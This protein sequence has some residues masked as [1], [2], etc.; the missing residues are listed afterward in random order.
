MKP[1]HGQDFLKAWE[2]WAK[3]VYD[4][5]LADGTIVSYSLNTEYYHTEAPGLLTAWY[6]IEDMAMDEKVSAAFEAAWGKPD[7]IDRKARQAY[8]RSLLVEGAHRDV[9]NRVLYY[10]AK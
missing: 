2:A 10:H 9:M 1:G 4:Q 6:L 7:E 5:L 3:P 8:I